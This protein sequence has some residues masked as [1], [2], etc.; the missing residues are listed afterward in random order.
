VRS[1]RRILLSAVVLLPAVG[2]SATR[3][4]AQA[5]PGTRLHR[6]GVQYMR[7]AAAAAAAPESPQPNMTYFGGP[8]FPNTTTYAIWWGKPSDFPS[9]ARGKIEEFLEGL[10][11]SAYL[12]IADQYM[13]GQ[14]AHTRFGGN[15]FDA[16]APTAQTDLFAVDADV[17]NEVAKVLQ[18]YGMKPDPNAVYMVY[19]SNFPNVTLNSVLFDVCAFHD[20]NYAPDGTVINYAYLPNVTNIYGC[21][22][23]EDP[24]IGRNPISQGTLEVASTT[25]HEFME[26]ITDAEFDGWHDPNY[27]EVGDPCV[28]L[29][30]SGVPLEGSKWEL[31]PIWS[32][33]V[34]GCA[35]GG[36][37][38][39]RILGALSNFGGI[40][41]FDIPDAAY[42]TF[43]ESINRDGT[44]VGSYEDADIVIHAF[45][46]NNLGHITM[47]DPPGAA[48]NFGVRALALGINAE[49]AIAGY[50]NDASGVSHGFVRDIHGKF[51]TL[52][53]PG[54]GNA[55]PGGTLASS[56][57]NEGAVAGRYVDANNVHH[58]FVRDSYGNFATFDA[59][60]ASNGFDS[61]TWA[62]SMNEEGAVTGYYLLDTKSARHGFVRDAY[63]NVATFDAPGAS[64][65]PGAGTVAFSINDEGVVAGYFTDAKFVQ[66]AFLRD[67]H[68]NFTTF[69]AP[70]AAYG[71]VARAINAQGLVAGYFSDEHGMAHGFVRDKHGNFNTFGALATSLNAKGA[72]AGYYSAPIP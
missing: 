47:I 23:F 5:A 71:T 35:Q 50:Y 70:G 60:G 3:A 37:H 26:T 28:Y 66:H 51:I 16:S 13:L 10:D 65:A 22:F 18:K 9:D 62:E 2:L 46:R 68:G 33:Q 21:A 58:G 19:T 15:L 11:G 67:E 72:I 8:V 12:A 24:F 43:A 30:Q 56:I 69:D 55:F 40:A 20:A 52:D 34:S 7:G 6:P 42:G 63:G 41:T 38:D 59:P 45:E 32:N 44:T 31:Q 27:V 1:L 48:S 57:N 39:V 29:P 25:A 53:A 4:K 64:N 61:G 49:G 17:N 14:K 36:S 54:A